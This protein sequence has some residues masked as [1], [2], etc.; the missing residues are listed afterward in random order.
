MH[1]SPAIAL[2]V[3]VNIAKLALL[4][5]AH[6]WEKRRGRHMVGKSYRLTVRASTNASDL[7]RQASVR[8]HGTTP[9][10]PQPSRPP[11][12]SNAHPRRRRCT[13]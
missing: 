13:L 1:C 9:L 3:V 12:A 5:R 4:T 7:G 10:R 6:H 2:V 8:M 11:S